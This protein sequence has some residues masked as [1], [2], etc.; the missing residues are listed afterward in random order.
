MLFEAFLVFYMLEV[1]V[2]VSVAVWY[3]YEP[4]V[5]EKKI[6]DPWVSG[7]RNKWL[8]YPNGLYSM[9]ILSH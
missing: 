5:Q 4:K 8:T 3:Y 1:L 2:L 7:R 9:A 6:W